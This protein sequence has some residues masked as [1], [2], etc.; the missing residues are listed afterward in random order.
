MGSSFAFITSVVPDLG[1]AMDG[2]EGAHLGSKEGGTGLEEAVGIS[3]RAESRPRDEPFWRA[4]WERPGRDDLLPRFF[5]GF[6]HGVP[7]YRRA[8]CA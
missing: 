6:T 5:L 8:P 7:K 2:L 1:P 4:R 3:L